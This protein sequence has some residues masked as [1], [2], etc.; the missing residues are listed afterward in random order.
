MLAAPGRPASLK[1]PSLTLRARGRV[2]LSAG[3]GA[4]QGVA[5]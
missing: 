4:D 3:A 2:G 5:R 1:A